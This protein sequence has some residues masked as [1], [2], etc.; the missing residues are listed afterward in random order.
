[1]DERLQKALEFSNYSLTINN[2][3]RNIKNRVQQLQMVHK[4]GGVF[5]AD[6]TTI[7]FIKTLI[8]LGKTS[9]ILIDTKENPVRISKLV[10]F[11]DILMSAYTSATTEFDIEYE[12]LKKARSIKKIMDWE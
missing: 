10:E 11:L 5:I 3:K 4:N 8:D 7:S 6:A 2:Q 9:T 1:M 12:K